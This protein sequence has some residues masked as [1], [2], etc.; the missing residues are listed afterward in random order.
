[1]RDR[2]GLIA[3]IRQVRRVAGPTD[4]AAAAGAA[5]AAGSAEATSAPGAISVSPAA[6]GASPDPQL[7]ALEARIAHLEQLV[8]GLQ[9]SVYREAERQSKLIA[10][11]EARMQPAALGAALSQNARERGL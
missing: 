11:L 8:E 1:M 7:R 9:D 3:R 4:A 5:D 2:E 6:G 10:E